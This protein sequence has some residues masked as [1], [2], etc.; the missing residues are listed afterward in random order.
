MN[1]YRINLIEKNDDF[2]EC[3]ILS[4]SKDDKIQININKKIK[5]NFVDIILSSRNNFFFKIRKEKVNIEKKI[6]ISINAGP[7]TK[8]TG[9]NKKNKNKMM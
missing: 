2:R 7:N 8:E 6:V 4:D 5:I 1:E 3:K 9:Q